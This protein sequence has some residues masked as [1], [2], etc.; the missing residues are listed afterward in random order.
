VRTKKVVLVVALAALFIGAL[1]FARKPKE[2]KTQEIQ[3]LSFLEGVKP[4]EKE[5]I[6]ATIGGGS[7]TVYT[8]DG[9]FADVSKR[10]TAD[11]EAMGLRKV[12]DQ[13]D[14]IVFGDDSLEITV[15]K[16]RVLSLAENRENTE[17]LKVSGPK[18]ER[19]A[20]EMVIWIPD[21]K[22]VSISVIEKRDDAFAKALNLIHEKAIER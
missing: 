5:A 21:E 6:P 13:G 9:N 2:T 19:Y 20:Y 15:N 1:T 8:F 7:R 12:R 11:F 18:Q 17:H 4:A 22:Q 10:A 14:S 3:Q 16:G